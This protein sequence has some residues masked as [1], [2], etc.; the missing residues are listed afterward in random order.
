MRLDWA[1]ERGLSATGARK[2]AHRL[3]PAAADRSAGREA[4]ALLVS[5][6][7]ELDAWQRDALVAAMGR[8]RSGRWAADEVR[9]LCPRQNGK[10]LCCSAPLCGTPPAP[11]TAHPLQEARDQDQP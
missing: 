4:A 11:G 2:P 6:G 5:L 3:V 8:D 10:T 9:L 7:V 1:G